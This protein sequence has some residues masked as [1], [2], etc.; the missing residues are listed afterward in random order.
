MAARRK[1]S[2]AEHKFEWDLT[3]F[4][5]DRWVRLKRVW[6]PSREELSVVKAVMDSHNCTHAEAVDFVLRE[7]EGSAL[8]DNVVESDGGG[9]GASIEGGV[10]EG[11]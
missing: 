5:A 9:V 11:D 4:S 6:A 8:K 7:I 1:P 2:K 10:G 3:R